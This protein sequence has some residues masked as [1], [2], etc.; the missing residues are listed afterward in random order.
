[1]MYFIPSFNKSLLFSLFIFISFSSYA[2]NMGGMVLNKATKTPLSKANISILKTSDSSVITQRYSDSLGRFFIPN[3]TESSVFVKCEYIGLKTYFKYYPILEGMNRVRIEMEETEEIL[4][5][6]GGIIKERQAVVQKNDTNEFS[7]SQFKVNKDASVEDLV[8]KMPGITMENGTIK[9]QGEEVKKVTVDG[10]DFFGNDASAA[11]KN[12]PA[13]IVSKVQV[14]DRMSDQAQFTGI[15]DGNGQ[16]SL[17][18]VTKAGRNKGQFGKIYAGYGTQDRWAA[19]G[20]INLFSKNHRISFIGLSNNINQQNFSTEDILSAVGGGAPGG[21]M[22]QRGG[23]SRGFGG[24]MWGGGNTSNF[25]LSQQ[26]GI[27]TSNSLGINYT[28]MNKKKLKLS[29]SYFFNNSRNLTQSYF[30]RTYFLTELENQYYDQ[31]DSSE[32]RSNSHRINAR[33]EYQFDS[34]N[35]IVYTPSIRFQNGNSISRFLG[36]TENDTLRSLNQSNSNNTNNNSGYNISNNVLF[37]HRFKK[38]GNTLSVQIN[39]SINNNTSNQLLQSEN[40]YFIPSYFNDAFRQNTD[41][42]NLSQSFSP[43]VSYTQTLSKKSFIELNYNPSFNQNNSTK[44]TTRFDTL[45]QSYQLVD[46]VLSNT[47]DNNVNTQRGGITYRYNQ[48]KWSFNIGAVLQESILKGEE[49]FPN[50]TSFSKPFTNVLPNA[51][52]TYQAS[53]TKS[54][55]VNYRTSTQ[56][57]S[58]SQLQNVVNNNN[59]LIL[60]S[61]NSLLKQEFSHNLFSRYSYTN[62]AKSTN[63]FAFI[64]AGLTQNYI[65]NS[66]TV[67]QKDTVINEVVLRKG[68]Q[69]TRPENIE[70][71]HRVRVFAT[72]GFPVKKLKSIIN[73][74]LG[75]TYSRIPT[76]INGNKNYSTTYATN[77]GIVWA[78]NISEALDFNLNYSVNYNTV[79][80]SLQE[81]L[82]N[83]YIIQTTSGKINWLIKE[84]VVLSSD[85]SNSKFNGL[86][87]AFNQSIWLWNAGLGY[88]FLKNKRGELKLSVFDLLNQNRS[89]NRT[90]AENYIED[91]NTQVLNRFF[92][93]SFIYQLRHF[94]YK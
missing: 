71:N 79:F 26:N 39:H 74:N 61:G 45:S 38:P 88:K 86:G 50:K 89:I 51:M 57:P 55:R 85:I 6:S 15:D 7:A 94:K 44:L 43:S 40:I 28:L 81:Q 17:N 19:G 16:K 8:K 47:F 54:I 56:L 46:S 68:S 34:L 12:L 21:G 10:Q 53:K 3:I 70:G 36:F 9:A 2:Q 41:N 30:E 87:D 59:P 58:L 52:I 75:Q 82:N 91:N 73:T 63:F 20:N 29:G 22:S 77:A 25:M 76:L 60:S 13:E 49:L 66:T 33:L 27:N 84:R 4:V 5:G 67:A 18:I 80:N 32:S 48:N 31:G 69:I 11:L 1:M 72:Y 83:A 37:R 23:G 35:S 93:V 92:M 24:M 90:V 62:T 64:S 65:G 78:S 42:T 14:F